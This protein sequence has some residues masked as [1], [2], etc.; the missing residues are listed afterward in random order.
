MTENVS[1]NPCYINVSILSAPYALTDTDCDGISDDE[2]TGSW[3]NPQLPKD[4]CPTVYNP[5]QQD[6]DGDRIGDACETATTTTAP[7]T[8]TTTTPQTVIELSS[9]T[10]SPLSGAVILKWSTASEIDNAGF[11]IYRSE[12][13][14]SQYTKI[15]TSLIPAKGSSTQGANYEFID[16]DVKNRKTYYY[17]LEDIDLNGNSTMHGPKSATPR[18]FYGIF[19]IF[20]K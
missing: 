11:N 1:A 16:N 5:N 20:K 10:A 17:K 7:P 19:E 13:E 2:C 15:N 12:S 3:C 14:V 8:T 6:S 18:W 9:F 4:N